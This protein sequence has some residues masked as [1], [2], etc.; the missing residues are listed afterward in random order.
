MAIVGLMRYVV[1]TEQV[2]VVGMGNRGGNGNEEVNLRLL[3]CTEFVQ[4][5]SRRSQMTPDWTIRYTIG[6][7][8]DQKG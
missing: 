5:R 7:L 1:L 6:R 2:Y 3:V 4:V 8:F